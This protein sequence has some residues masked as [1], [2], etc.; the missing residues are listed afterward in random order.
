MYFQ[1]SYLSCLPY[2]EQLSLMN[3]PCVLMTA[4]TPCFD[5]R[6]FIINWCPSLQVLD[7]YVVN[8]KESLKAEWLYSQGK[9]RH[10]KPGQHIEVISYLASVCPLTSA[11]Q[12]ELQ[13]DAKLSQILNKQ[14]YHQQQLHQPTSVKKYSSGYN[15]LSA[16]GFSEHNH[17]LVLQ[18]SGLNTSGDIGG[19]QSSYNKAPVTA[20]T[21]NNKTSAEVYYGGGSHS[22]THCQD[23]S[24]QDFVDDSDTKSQTSLLDSESIY[25]PISS[26]QM[27]KRPMTAPAVSSPN[28]E[29]NISNILSSR[30]YRPATVMETKYDAYDRR[31]VKPLK[32]NFQYSPPLQ[33]GNEPAVGAKKNR[34][35]T[36]QAHDYD[37]SQEVSQIEQILSPPKENIPAEELSLIKD[38]ADRKS[39]KTSGTSSGVS[40]SNKV[41]TEKKSTKHQT[42]SE[43]KSDT[44][45]S[46]IPIS[47]ATKPSNL[48]RTQSENLPGK[49]AQSSRKSSEQTKVKLSDR[50]DN[51]KDSTATTNVRDS[52]FSSRPVSDAVLDDF[53]PEE[54]K[55]AIKIQSF[56][57]GFYARKY[58]PDIVCVRKEIRAQRAEDHIILLRSE[59]ERH[60][61]MYEEEKHLRSLQLEAIR[62]LWKEVQ[63]LQMWKNEVLTSQAF[64][65]MDSSGRPDD[66]SYN[67]SAEIQQ[68]LEKMET[69][70]KT[71]ESG[72]GTFSTQTTAPVDIE[73][74][75]ELE[76]TC[77]KLQSQI[78]QLQQSLQSVSS[79]VFQSGMITPSLNASV[80]H[81]A[82][83]TDVPLMVTGYDDDDTS[84]GDESTI[85][86]PKWGLVPHSLSPY[87]SEEEEAYFLTVA[88]PGLPTP[89]RNLRL[90]HKGNN[91]VV[92]SWQASRILDAHRREMNKPLLGYRVFV[93]DK[94]AAMIGDSLKA[95]VYGLDPQVTYKIF[96]KAV[97][98]VGESNMSN[99]VMAALCTAVSGA[100]KRS[101]SSDSNRSDSEKDLDSTESSDV[102]RHRNVQRRQRRIKSPRQDKRQISSRGKESSASDQEVVRE[103]E[104]SSSKGERPSS[105][106]STKSG[107]SD[108]IL[109][110]PKLH[111]HKR[112][113]SKDYQNSN[114]DVEATGATN[115]LET[116]TP[117]ESLLPPSVANQKS[118]VSYSSSV[119]SETFT[120]D[121]QGSLFQAINVANNALAQNISEHPS[122]KDQSVK[123]HK[124]KRSK[125]L[126]TAELN[127]LSSD[128]N[129]SATSVS[130]VNIQISASES[131]TNVKSRAQEF[132]N[133]NTQKSEQDNKIDS[134]KVQ[135]H[136]RSRSKDLQKEHVYEWRKDIDNTSVKDVKKQTSKDSPG[137]EGHGIPIID[138]RKRHSSGSRPSSPAP[139]EVSEPKNPISKKTV[140]DILEQK[141]ST[142][143]SVG[144]SV[145]K[146]STLGGTD[147]SDPSYTAALPPRHRRTGSSDESDGKRTPSKMSPTYV[148]RRRTPSVGSESDFSLSDSAAARQLDMEKKSNSGIVTKLLQKLQTF[149]KSQEETIREQRHKIKKKSTSDAPV[150]STEEGGTRRKRQIS[151]SESES[152]SDRTAPA[153]DSSSGP[154]SDESQSVR[155]G[156]T[157]RRRVTLAYAL[158][159]Y[160]SGSDHKAPIIMKEPSTSSRRHS[161]SPSSVPDAG[162]AVSTTTNVKRTASFHGVLTKPQEVKPRRSGSEENLSDKAVAQSMANAMLYDCEY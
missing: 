126:K 57:R 125:D 49:Y 151:G 130:N 87:P 101:S 31:P 89:P 47:K 138:A 53:S 102:I 60:K 73:R 81:S 56:W 161:P 128:I 12:L 33:S 75:M 149:S 77:A 14:K 136:K 115:S 162:S 84:S 121:T 139:A 153:S 156:K 119:M 48:H 146:G 45:S 113:R 160:R 110:Q 92:L 96:V 28:I 100:R 50:T 134:P 36:A 118:D 30:D 143:S 142:K 150:V 91:S 21:A 61:R 41:T 64:K 98:A 72:R 26:D 145:D 5:C 155:K 16:D 70:N 88:K 135:T 32:P 93:D 10:F 85:A 147:N 34:P 123:T 109:T 62:F 158:Y 103:K 108:G 27:L 29:T 67:Y 74:H 106:R 38:I 20:W 40:G 137:A 58:N 90:I 11:S 117:I 43:N 95:L 35:P 18:Q 15:D 63:S 116:P 127:N 55:A 6:P 94:P 22:Q 144:S 65:T 68:T 141:F 152:I 13:E 133:R 1:V 99:V 122:D 25:L 131:S 79:V 3:N 114:T 37:T 97:S 83:E 66:S 46:S 39:K 86:G 52:G 82:G 24:I 2:L 129:Q 157:H 19:S 111:T 4:S 80:N 124:R 71:V 17:S 76:K 69:M 159:T 7:G 107:N 105:S 154:A 9:G 140:A 51:K 120:V 8:E 54:H 148:E 132:E 59:L 42:K 104:H 23:I 112:N 44:K 78:A